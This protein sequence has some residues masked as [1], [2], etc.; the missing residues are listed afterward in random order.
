[1]ATPCIKVCALDPRSGRCLGCGRT[2]EEIAQ[3][4][5]LSD[6]ERARVMA[7][8]PARL[9]ASRSPETTAG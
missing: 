1:M 4:T 2:I 9:A 7:E 8:L 3:W 6:E 5:L